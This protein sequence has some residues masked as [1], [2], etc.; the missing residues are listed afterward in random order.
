M[1]DFKDFAPFI[2]E[3]I[4]SEGWQHLRQIQLDAAEAIF[5]PAISK[6]VP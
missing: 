2:Q 3:Y 4:Y 6:A 1:I 5:L